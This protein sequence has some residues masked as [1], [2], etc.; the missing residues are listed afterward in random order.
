MRFS[1]FFDLKGRKTMTQTNVDGKLI[2]EI[3]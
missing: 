3:Q 1:A 2:K